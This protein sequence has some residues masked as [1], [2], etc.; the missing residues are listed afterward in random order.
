MMIVETCRTEKSYS[1]ERQLWEKPDS[2]LFRLE[3][4]ARSKM[5]AVDTSRNATPAAYNA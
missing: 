5:T 3:F 4:T 1:K 2:E